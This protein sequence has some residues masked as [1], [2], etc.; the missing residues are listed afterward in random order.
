MMSTPVKCNPE[1][2]VL[3]FLPGNS[4]KYVYVAVQEKYT[5]LRSV[6]NSIHTYALHSTSKFRSPRGSSFESKRLD[7]KNEMKSR[8][9]FHRYQNEFSPSQARRRAFDG[10]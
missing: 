9:Y 4:K 3:Y 5:G 7:V 8:R 6:S 1:T 2:V 10:P